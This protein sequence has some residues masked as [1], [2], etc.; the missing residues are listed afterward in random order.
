MV[1][2][3]GLSGNDNDVLMD[4]LLLVL[5]CVYGVANDGSQSDMNKGRLKVRK[6]H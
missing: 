5:A 1:G 6:G 4:L 2:V 3:L